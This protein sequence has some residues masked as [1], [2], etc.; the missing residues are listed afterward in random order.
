MQ[1]V[2]NKKQVKTRPHYNK[3]VHN[4]DSKFSKEKRK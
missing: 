4:S 1:K 2:Y 3:F